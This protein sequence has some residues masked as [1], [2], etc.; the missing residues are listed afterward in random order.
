MSTKKIIQHYAIESYAVP[1]SNMDLRSAYMFRRR[2]IVD[3]FLQWADGRVFDTLID[4]GSSTGFL[5]KKIKSFMI[6]YVICQ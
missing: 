5:T 3:A 6:N 4:I 2:L 1:G